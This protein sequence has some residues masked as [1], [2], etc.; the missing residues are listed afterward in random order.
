[1]RKPFA[2][3]VNGGNGIGQYVAQML[4]QNGWEVE[5]WDRGDQPVDDDVKYRSVDVQWRSE[6]EEAADEL[7]DTKVDALILCT[8]KAL[9]AQL[10]LTSG[11]D[12]EREI[13]RGPKA[14]IMLTQCLAANLRNGADEDGGIIFHIGPDEG[15]GLTGAVNAA[16]KSII[17][18][19][20]SEL[21]SRD[22]TTQQI[23]F[24]KMV[25]QAIEFVA[26]LLSEKNRQRPFN[27]ESTF[28]GAND[29]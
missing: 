19:F 24:G 15:E 11:G 27:G 25:T 22:I 3:I 18:G 20:R 2:I 7:K 13:D 26:F 6:I 17:A 21:S 16:C 10:G 5:C 4:S 12:W 29:V 23:I 14:L 9:P 8:H 28:V 1:M